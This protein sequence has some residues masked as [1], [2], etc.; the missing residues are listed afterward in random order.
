MHRPT[1]ILLMLLLTA[2]ATI[3]CTPAPFSKQA[4]IAAKPKLPTIVT[5]TGRHQSLTISASPGA[6]LYSVADKSGRVLLTNASEAELAKQQPHLHRLL[7]ANAS[8][9]QQFIA[10]V[11][12]E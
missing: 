2:A 3:S 7:D 6:P 10:D 1:L 8:A 9:D 12:R 11:D 5:V 4:P